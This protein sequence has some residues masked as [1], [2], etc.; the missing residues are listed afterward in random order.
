MHP[1]LP[2]ILLL[3]FSCS[4]KPEQKSEEYPNLDETVDT[5]IVKNAIDYELAGSSYRKRGDSYFLVIGTDTSS[6]KPIFS[7][8]IETGLV[9]LSLNIQYTKANLSYEK[10]LLELK[11][12]LARAAQDY[13]LD[14]L[15]SISFGR[16]I[17]SGDLAITVTK[18]YEESFGQTEQISIAQYQEISKFL[19]TSTLSKDLNKLLKPYYRSVK[20]VGIEKAFFTTKSEL[21][22]Y[23]CVE[24]DTS[25]IPSR[26]L[27]FMTWIEI[28]K[29]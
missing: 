1:P 23:A 3:L 18:E 7:E 9:S 6:F 11:H 16:L 17:L 5:M 19:L 12:L 28:G 26:I 8:A 15:Q 22:D 24:Q 13:T 29:D 10:R 2:F 4:P 27:D 20:H 21:L 14:S 25:L